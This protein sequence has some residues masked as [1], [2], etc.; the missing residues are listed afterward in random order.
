MYKE[1]QRYCRSAFVSNQ[2]VLRALR[3]FCRPLPEQRTIADALDGLNNTI[4]MART[5][6][7]RLKSL[8]HSIAEELLTGRRRVD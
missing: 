7:D 8:G 5:E 3:M 6:R 4:E 2:N 1:F